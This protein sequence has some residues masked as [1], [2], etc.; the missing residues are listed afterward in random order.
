VKPTGGQEN[1]I[2]ECI[3]SSHDTRN[4][5]EMRENEKAVWMGSEAFGRYLKAKPA[6]ALRGSGANPVSGFGGTRQAFDADQ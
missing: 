2:S 4:V 3:D 5:L 1:G 6:P